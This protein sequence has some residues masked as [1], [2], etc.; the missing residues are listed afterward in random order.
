MRQ[1][2]TEASNESFA[3]NTGFYEEKKD[4]EGRQEKKRGDQL[5]AYQKKKR[6]R[7]AFHM[8][9]KESK[10]VAAVIQT[11]VRIIQCTA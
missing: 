10:R 8:K 5:R 7:M 2:C 6:K 4:E 9:L 3:G 1:V 11:P